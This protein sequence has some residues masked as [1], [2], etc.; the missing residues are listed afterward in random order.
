M[1][2]INEYFE[3]QWD[4]AYEKYPPHDDDFIE[5][6]RKNSH[7]NNLFS[8][9]KSIISKETNT[10]IPGTI[11]IKINPNTQNINQI[12]K[13]IKCFIPFTQKVIVFIEEPLEYDEYICTYPKEGLT[14]NILPTSSLR[15]YAELYIAIEPAIKKNIAAIIPSNILR[16]V[17]DYDDLAFR[18]LDKYLF[19]EMDY[20]NIS[21]KISAT[22]VLMADDNTYKREIIKDKKVIIT[23]NEILLNKYWSN[24]FSRIGLYSLENLDIN[25]IISFQENNPKLFEIFNNRI[26]RSINSF[27]KN[28]SKDEI[29]NLIEETIEGI[30][31]MQNHLQKEINRSKALIGSS[32]AM[33]GL[34]ALIMSNVNYD[35][36]K[37]LSQIIG[38]GSFNTILS[39]ILSY[40][41]LKSELKTHEYYIPYE[42]SRKFDLK[43]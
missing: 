17:T 23:E 35:I 42:I 39:K 33:M 9:I 30:Y 11:L 27:D 40:S 32:V 36:I 1:P 21:K 43:I 37:Y 2:S 28:K 16:Y 31:K 10:T 18:L 8:E 22:P 4:K 14:T 34:S 19:Q 15:T 38:A 24:L 29:K 3:H 20:A 12:I 41:N 7:T 25:T 6:S 5:R 26:I 13:T